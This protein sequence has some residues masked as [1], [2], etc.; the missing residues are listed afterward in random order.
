M[1]VRA[2]GKSKPTFRGAR[3]FDPVRDLYAVARILEE[4][5][6]PD[7]AFPLSRAPFLREVGIALWTMSY[8]PVFPEDI[9]GFVW[10]EDGKVVGNLTL[11]LVGGHLD[12][13][14]ISNVAVKPSYQRRGIAR[15]LMQTAL[16]DL[17]TRGAKWV[18]LNTRPTNPGALKLYLDLGFQEIEMQGE[19]TSPTSPH[20]P[21]PLLPSPDVV[22]QKRGEGAKGVRGEVV[23]LL[24]SSDNPAAAEL[25]RAA[26]PA[27]VQRFRAPRVSEFALNW[28]D[29]VTEIIADFFI[30]QTTRRWALEREGKLAALLMVRGQRIASP[31]RIAIEVHPEV[32]GHVES[33]LV[34]LA[35][36]ELARFPSREI[37]AAAT[38]THP[39]LIAALEQ[40]GFKFLNG[41]TTMALAIS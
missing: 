7:R 39:E 29:R 30:G 25:I 38:S 40:H 37:R 32:R 33:E 34:A 4:A 10:V 41:L 6:R 15:A 35:L 31:H 27:D 8:M 22:R 16:D 18:L 17:R 12:R 9:T 23:R 5:F 20:S 19:W 13:Y 3:P 21:Q 1:V 24:R 26:T 36:Q 11:S 2:I 14:A 28:E